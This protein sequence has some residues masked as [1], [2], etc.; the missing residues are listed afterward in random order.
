[1]TNAIARVG[2][3]RHGTKLKLL[4]DSD[5]D[6]SVSVLPESH[7]VGEHRIEFCNSGGKSHHTMKALRRLFE[8]M[9]KDAKERPDGNP[10]RI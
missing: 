8:A 5:G 2:D 1:M 6:I 4:K 3:M 10:T 9:E 7:F